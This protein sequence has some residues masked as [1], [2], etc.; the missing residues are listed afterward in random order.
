MADVIDLDV[1]TPENTIHHEEQIVLPMKYCR[2]GIVNR[3]IGCSRS[4]AYN[5]IE[6]AEKTKG[7]EGISLSISSGLK[8]VKLSVLDDFLEYKN[9]KWL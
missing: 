3:Y 7:F 1:A 8:L 4:T 9:K 2:I 5:L 6:E